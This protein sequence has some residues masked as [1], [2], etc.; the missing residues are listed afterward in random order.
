MVHKDNYFWIAASIFVLSIV[1]AAI[2][3]NQLWFFLMIVSYLLRP[4]LV[5]LG[6]GKRTIDERQM[7]LHYRSGN[8]AFAVMVA[9]SIV[10]AVI[11]SE[12]D[13]HTW[14]L[15]NIVIV[16]GLAAK[17]LFNVLLTKDYR[18][19][20]IRIILSVGLLMVLFAAAEEGISLGS[21]M[22]SL[23]GLAIVG[24][25]LTARKYPKPVSICVFVATAVLLLFIF[26]KG[27]TIG[28]ITTALLIGVPMTLA[29]LSLLV[30]PPEQEEVIR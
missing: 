27:F 29:G 13:D 30:S 8:I 12:K 23:P 17:A 4:T 11:Q 5:S 15:F 10:L 18:E 25:G 7:L 14:E 26:S 16:L 1:L 20:G 3:Q 24:I 2:T 6:I 22:H 9:A 28:Q 19:A 21:L